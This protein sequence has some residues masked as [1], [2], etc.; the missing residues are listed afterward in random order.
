MCIVISLVGCVFFL[1]QLRPLM[2]NRRMTFSPRLFFVLCVLGLIVVVGVVFKDSIKEPHEQYLS[3][4]GVD[5]KTDDSISCN[6]PKNLVVPKAYHAWVERPSQYGY[7]APDKVVMKVAFPSMRPWQEVPWLDWAGTEQIEVQIEDLRHDPLA[8]SVRNIQK[9]C[10]NCLTESYAA[11]PDVLPGYETWQ[12]NGKYPQQVLRV[13]N[14]HPNRLLFCAGTI[15]SPDEFS[16]RCFTSTLV[17][18]DASQTESMQ[19]MEPFGLHV[20]YR[21]NRT[22]ITQSAEMNAKVT[23]MVQSFSVK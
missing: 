10:V 21:H 14:T 13:R 3:L 4:C 15:A 19:S 2:F 20:I 22:L 6:N 11:V 16:K 7:G 23:Q 9:P 8:A 18:L 5:P 17:P 1:Y 12:R